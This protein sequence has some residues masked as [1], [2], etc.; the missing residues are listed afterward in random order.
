MSAVHYLCTLLC[1][2]KPINCTWKSMQSSVAFN[3]ATELNTG[4]IKAANPSLDQTHGQGHPQ[5][6]A[7]EMDQSKSHTRLWALCCTSWL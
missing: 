1:L 6:A 4:P 2:T 7:C 5:E 3:Q